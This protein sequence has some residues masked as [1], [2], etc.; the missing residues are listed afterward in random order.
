MIVFHL[1]SYLAT[2]SVYRWKDG[3][4]TCARFCSF[5]DVSVQFSWV[6]KYFILLVN[7]DVVL[8]P[9]V[10][11]ILVVRVFDHYRTFPVV[12]FESFLIDDLRASNRFLRSSSLSEI[13]KR[14]SA[15]ARI[16]G[17][18]QFFVFPV[19]LS[20]DPAGFLDDFI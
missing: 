20:R 9:S 5:L 17:S 10:E 14:F 16:T 11:D 3:A 12:D 2:V 15:Y 7:L 13:A 4:Q 19:E 1:S 8:L 6:P 18:T